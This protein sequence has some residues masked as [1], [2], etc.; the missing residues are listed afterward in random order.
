MLR[1]YMYLNITYVTYHTIK[2]QEE[3]KNLP[4]TYTCVTKNHDIFVWMQNLYNKLYCKIQKIK[5]T[6]YFH[7]M[8]F[9]HFFIIH[10]LIYLHLIF[11]L[12]YSLTDSNKETNLWPTL[13]VLGSGGRANRA[14]SGNVDPAGTVSEERLLLYVWNL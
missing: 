3:L 5:I 7:K 8:L 12:E 13:G 1:L 6:A 11:F 9:M 4:L 14:S 2:L 10:F